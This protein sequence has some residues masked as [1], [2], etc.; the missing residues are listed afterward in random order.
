MYI[1]LMESH[2]WDLIFFSSISGPGPKKYG[3]MLGEWSCSR[4]WTDDVLFL[5]YFEY[6]FCRKFNMLNY[7]GMTD[8]MNKMFHTDYGGLKFLHG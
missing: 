4:M 6:S 8:E 1:V 2:K 5:G 7:S 3:E